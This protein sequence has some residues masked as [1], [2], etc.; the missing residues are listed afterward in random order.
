MP[1]RIQFSFAGKCGKCTL[2]PRYD[3][4]RDGRI[5]GIAKGVNLCTPFIFNIRIGKRRRKNIS[6]PMRSH[7][8]RDTLSTG[9][10]REMK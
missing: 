1:L 2:H 5:M 4:A 9:G 6:V 7:M 10:V 3:P 8:F